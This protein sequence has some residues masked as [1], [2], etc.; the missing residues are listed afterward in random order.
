MNDQ[1]SYQQMYPTFSEE[2]SFPEELYSEFSQKTSLNDTYH[3]GEQVS[4]E[5]QFSREN[6]NYHQIVNSKFKTNNEV[7]SYSMLT[8]LEQILKIPDTYISSVDRVPRVDNVYDINMKK[9]SPKT[10][11]V[12][13]GLERLFLEIISN[14]GDNVHRSRQSGVEPYKIEVSMDKN[15]ITIKNYGL[16]IPPAIHPIHQIYV[17]EMVF[18][19]LLTSGNYNE[20]R[21]GAGRNGYG[22]KLTN[23]YSVYFA[24]DIVDTRYG[25]RYRQSWSDNMHKKENPIIEQ[26][27]SGNVSYVQVTYTVDL[28]RFGYDMYIGYPQEALELFMRHSIDTS[29]TNKIPVIFNG[30]T[31]N[32]DL[33]VYTSLLGDT[34][35]RFFH[36]EWPPNT[37][38]TT[39]KTGIQIAIDSRI[40][41]TVEMSIID[42]PDNGKFIA[43]VNGIVTPDGGPHVDSAYRAVGQTSIKALNGEQKLLN[44]SDIKKHL[45]LVISIRVMNP[46]FS[47]QSKVKLI[48]PSTIRIGID[49]TIIKKIEKWEF[50]RQLYA[51]LQA[52][53]FKKLKQTDGKGGRHI[54]IEK[55]SDA[56]KAGT[57][58][59]LSCTLY[60]VEGKSA[61]STAIKIISFS[62]GS[63]Y[64][65]AYPIRGKMLN[66]RGIS[67]IKIA[68]NVEIKEL[69]QILNLR[70]GVDY[71][72]DNN[73]AKLRYGRVCILADSDP[74]GFHIAGLII[75]LFSCNYK[76]LL[77]RGFL[78][79]MRTPIIKVM[80]NSNNYKF[81]TM[82]E[83]YKWCR[84]TP[85]FKTWKTQYYKG[86]G[87]LTDADIKDEL[88]SPRVTQFFNDIDSDSVID[89]A[90][91]KKKADV[92]KDWIMEWKQNK[93]FLENNIIYEPL[94]FFIKNEMI[95]YPIE[96]LI[97]AIPRVDGLK[98][99]Q[100]K[101]MWVILQHYMNKMAKIENLAADI[102]NKTSYHHGSKSLEDAITKI[103]QD[104]PGS[105]NLPLIHG[106]G[107]FGTRVE[108]GDAAKPRYVEGQGSWC[109]KYLYPKEDERLYIRVEDDGVLVEVES[110]YPILPTHLINGVIG[111]AT[112]YSTFIPSFNP[113]CLFEWYRCKIMGEDLP[114]LI[115]WYRGYNGIITPLIKKVNPK[116]K[117]NKSDDCNDLFEYID[118]Q[119]EIKMRQAFKTDGI[120]YID[121]TGALHITELPLFTWTDTYKEWLTE[122]VSDKKISSFEH[123]NTHD[124][125][126][127]IIRGLGFEPN[128]KSL[129]LTRTFSMGNMT[130]INNDAV[131]IKYNNLNEA[132]EDFYKFR[133][134]AYNRRKELKLLELQE[135]IRE[136]NEKKRFIENVVYGR[137][138]VFK[139][140]KADVLSD[141]ARMKHDKKYINIKTYEYTADEI[142]ELEKK[143]SKLINEY[144][145]LIMTEPKYIWLKEL[146]EF[147]SEYF[148]HYQY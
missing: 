7:T 97:R 91:D 139:R 10:I 138:I 66:V 120:F 40:L 110:L 125:I 48:K 114:S 141:M 25:I 5:N 87:R 20:Q 34:K 30:E 44:I 140:P 130:I 35:N 62:G 89:M 54:N 111:I 22:A 9:I 145:E 14:A 36:Y 71:S 124:T 92:R 143:I 68:D 115:P 90:F 41:P 127:F 31:F 52:K 11:S 15:T 116:K 148:K 131:P 21:T 12:P 13:L 137:L 29:F 73:Y 99:S 104:F 32:C 78:Y 70:E 26:L 43:F 93:F 100:R 27:T 60:I 6:Q 142:L 8:L 105:N 133:I 121:N 83:Y 109:L 42:T 75:N 2:F 19:H 128:L 146:N 24:I 3:I 56:N 57:N 46:T 18:G 81:Y 77:E 69:K 17:P 23:I 112:G 65:G 53:E 79:F 58:E 101:I 16:A 28:P 55:C 95:W 63:N 49:P 72:D 86:I 119:D 76:G 122:L 106:E 113:W 85:G 98:I 47:S 117:N 39:T 118:D 67:P 134:D 50:M 147:I 102:S 38:F 88:K 59:S 144:N 61:K 82:G 123:H 107:Q 96:V 1:I 129:K 126:H 4:Q 37:Q 51:S 64:L 74:D 80:K 136:L 45:T 135:E 132:L 94:W 33:Q 103:C 84:E 108:G